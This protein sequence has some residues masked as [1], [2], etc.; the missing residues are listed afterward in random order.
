MFASAAD[1]RGLLGGGIAAGLMHLEL[2]EL[3][4]KPIYQA[5]TAD[6]ALL[7][8]DDFES[9]PWGKKYP[10]IARPGGG[11]GSRP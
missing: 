10:A 3:H 6:A 2:V 11:K 5:P 8:L 9:S 4:P 1:W 7:A